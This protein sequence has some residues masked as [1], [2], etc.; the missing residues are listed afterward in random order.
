MTA[1]RGLTEAELLDI[2]ENLSDIV[3]LSESEDESDVFEEPTRQDQLVSEDNCNDNMHN[4]A[5]ISEDVENADNG[6]EEE[7]DEFTDQNEIHSENKETAIK[8][9]TQAQRLQNFCAAHNLTYKQDIRWK[10]NVQY[11]TPINWYQKKNLNSP[12][13]SSGDPTI[14]YLTK[15]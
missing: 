3:A 8:G 5:E 10:P 15:Q 13:P 12:P 11:Q 4:N 9:P 14:R 2:I 6:E 7:P 1:R